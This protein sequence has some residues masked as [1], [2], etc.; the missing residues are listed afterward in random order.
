MKK[1]YSYQNKKYYE[2]YVSKYRSK[3]ERIQKRIRFDKN[4]KRISSKI[5]ANRLEY[6]L[7][8]E[9]D[10]INEGVCLWTWEKWHN[11][12]L[13][14]MRLTHKKSSLMC[15]DGD[16]KKWLSKN[17][18]ER[19]LTDFTRS[20]VYDFIFTELPTTL[21]PTRKHN[22]LK[23]LRKIF[24][25]AHEEGII[26]INP[27]KGIKVKIPPREQK[28][29]STE[30]VQELL[31][32][33]KSC[34]H[35]YYSLWAFALFTG[36]RN[37]EI[38]A[39]RHSDIDLESGL[40]HVNKQFTSKDGIHETKG[41]CNR[42]IPICKELRSF[43]IELIRNGGYKET[44]WRWEDKDNS[45]KVR[46]IWND[47]L[48]PRHRSWRSGEQSKILKKFCKEMGIT[49]VKFH[50]LRATFI[51]NMLSRGVPLTVVMKIVG[52]SQMSTTDEYN[53]LAGVGVKGFTEH[54][55]YHLPTEH[56]EKA[57]NVLQLFSKNKS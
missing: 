31:D 33:G 14:R 36:M 21:S 32:K 35:R 42:V 19:E 27:T 25:L 8:K 4:G 12:C 44:L 47:L 43:L 28:V 2:I 11:E 37:G 41:N 23:A 45:K 52:H 24:E 40:I 1:I 17:W 55:G 13:K 9:L 49:E 51:T 38:Y 53:R 57:E 3:G 48:L 7:K 15:Y 50:D 34:F 39:I 5:V 26:N 18:Q 6:Q 56:Q 30:D 10:G 22:M 16:V 54:L 29:L 20:H 46:V